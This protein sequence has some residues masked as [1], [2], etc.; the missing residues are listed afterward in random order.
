M[1]CSIVDYG[2]IFLSSCNVNDL[3]DLQ[4]LQ[5]H[6]LHCC[7]KIA[8]PREQ[9]VTDLHKISDIALVDIRRKI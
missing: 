8:D 3:C 6:A 1:F 4:T 5:N 9:H 7:H 2:N